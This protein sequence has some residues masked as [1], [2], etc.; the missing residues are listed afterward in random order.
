V[1]ASTLT[2]AGLFR[3]LRARLQSFVDRRFY[4]SRYDATRTVEVFGM[5]LR[6]ETDLDEL[7]G[8]LV[9]VVRTTM[10]PEHVSIWLRRV[11]AGDERPPGAPPAGRP[12]G[13]DVRMSLPR[14]C[15]DLHAVGRL[16][17]ESPRARLRLPRLSG[18]TKPSPDQLHR[19]SA[20]Q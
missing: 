2:V 1:N 6:D 12:V 10:Q 9:S 5:R 7:T 8:D 20:R 13:N 14:R 4:R 3:P 15:R 16:N 11:E 18:E 19:W 17:A